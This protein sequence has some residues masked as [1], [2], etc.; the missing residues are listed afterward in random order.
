MPPGVV[1]LSVEMR[2]KACTQ[3]TPP[4]IPSGWCCETA[5]GADVSEEETS[6]RNAGG[7]AWPAGGG[8]GGGGLGQTE[9]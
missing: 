4:A 8:R 2:I 5:R 6:Q 1:W 9:G 7:G 3:A